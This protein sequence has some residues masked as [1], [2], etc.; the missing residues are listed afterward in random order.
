MK[1]QANDFWRVAS[2]ATVTARNLANTRGSVATPCFMEDAI[3][4]MVDSHPNKA[5]V[6]ELRVLDA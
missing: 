1:S 3:R 5:N 6:K 4:K 2:K